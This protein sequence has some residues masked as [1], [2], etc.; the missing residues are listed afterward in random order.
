M[1]VHYQHH[2]GDTAHPAL[3]RSSHPLRRPGLYRNGAKRLLDIVLVL[4][5]LPF[6]VPLVLILALAVARDGGRPFYG[7]ARV[8]RGGRIF[9]MWKLRSMQP[10][11]DARLAEY[12]AASPEARAEWNARQKLARDPRITRLGRFL[13]A[14]SLDEL[15]QLWNV[16]RGDMSLVGPRPMMPEQRPLYPGEAYYALRPG[17]TGPWQVSARS[18]STFAERAAFDTGYEADLSL[19]TDLRLLFATVG[20]VTRG[21]GC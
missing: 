14:S 1:T 4:L 12:L 8:G 11:A 15:P 6:V 18:R 16:L 17:L 10:D 21:T 3:P 2:L 20:A 13:R 9:R 19:G 7:Q 5:A